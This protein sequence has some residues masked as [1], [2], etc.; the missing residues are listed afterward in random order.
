MYYYGY[1][2]DYSAGGIFNCFYNCSD[3]CEL[4]WW[5]DRFSYGDS[6]GW[7]GALYV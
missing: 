3:Q 1:G 7:H 6:Y 2:Y 5:Y 4:L